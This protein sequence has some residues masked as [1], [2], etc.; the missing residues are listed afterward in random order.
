M[1]KT[2]RLVQ[3]ESFSGVLRTPVMFEPSPALIEGEEIYDVSSRDGANW[4]LD[5]AR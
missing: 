2:N 5:G 3:F 1:D 4:F